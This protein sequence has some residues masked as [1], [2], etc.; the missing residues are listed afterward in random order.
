MG[1]TSPQKQKKIKNV[2]PQTDE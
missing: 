1:N 2:L